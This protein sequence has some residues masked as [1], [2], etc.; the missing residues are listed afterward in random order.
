MHAGQVKKRTSLLFFHSSLNDQQFEALRKKPVFF[1]TRFLRLKSSSVYFFDSELLVE[2]MARSIFC[3][4]FKR[5]ERNHRPM[6][7]LRKYGYRLL[8]PSR[9]YRTLNPLSIALFS[10][11]ELFSYPGLKERKKVPYLPLSERGGGGSASCLFS[12]QAPYPY[13]FLGWHN[14]ERECQERT[15]THHF[16]RVRDRQ[17]APIDVKT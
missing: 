7:L 4:R 9:H 17:G 14:K 6:V 10:G 16:W 5:K 12:S 13:L 1:G 11:E 2:L 15:H 3:S 8:I